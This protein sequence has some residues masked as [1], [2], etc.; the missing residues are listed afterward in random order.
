MRIV[1][2]NEVA[3]YEAPSP[4]R[5]RA[6]LLI[7]SETVGARSCSMGM[8]FFDPGDKNPLHS[9]PTDEIQYVAKGRGTFYTEK[10][11]V[12]LGEGAAIYI[13]SGEKHRLENLGTQTLW[14]LWVYAPP[15]EEAAIRK[16]QRKKE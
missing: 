3:E 9:H 13:P 5:R 2:L 8:S 12:E 11:A 6:K 10:D 1:K 7:D 16:W 15:G 14:L 4:F